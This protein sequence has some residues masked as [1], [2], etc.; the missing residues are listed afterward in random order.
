MRQ[1]RTGIRGIGIN[2]EVS[3]M[4]EQVNIRLPDG[5]VEQYDA[6]VTPLEVAGRI[7]ARLAAAAVAAKVNGKSVDLD[8]KITG[9][10]DLE[11]ITAD[12]DE[13]LEILRHSAAHIMAQAVKRLFPEARLGI[14]PAIAEGFYY[15]FDIPQRLSDDDLEQIEAEMGRIVSADYEFKRSVM[16]AEEAR[17]LF[18]ASGEVYKLELVDDI[19]EDYVSIYQQG[20]FTDL[21]RGPHIPATGR[22]KAFKLLS[23]AGAYWQGDTERPMLQRV[24]G[25]AFPKNKELEEYIEKR[26]EAEKRDHRKLGQQLDL[27]SFHDAGPGFPFLHPKGLIIR[28]QLEDFL[29]EE[30]RRRGYEEIR[31]PVILNEGLWH[32]SGHWDHYKENMY[33][34]QIDDDGYAI[35]PMN[36]PGAML[37]YR[38]KLHSYR[39]L[40]V[41]LCEMGVVHRHELS[42]VLQGLMR[43]RCFTQDDAHLF[44]TPEQIRDEIKGIIQLIDYVYRDVFG[45]DY[46]IELSTRPENSMGSDEIWEHA[47]KAL[48]DALH[49]LNRGFSVNE[50]DGAFYGPKIDFHLRDCLDRTWQCGTIQLDFLMP[51][52]FGLEYV[53][54]DGEKHRP[55]VIH[56]TV[57]GSLERFMG[58]LIE[59]FAGAFPTW[60]APVQVMMIPVSS[61]HR[62]YARQAE[63]QLEKNGIRADVDER[64]EKV[65][66]KIRD[67][68]L[69]QVPYMLIVGE[70]EVGSGT[71]SVRHRREGDMGERSLADFI[72][73]IRE[74]IA[75]RKLPEQT[76]MAL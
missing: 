57:Y 52:R 16:P 48:R 19:G 13:G 35:K 32:Q 30:L 22:L 70:N 7:G 63:A 33:F 74:E 26:K 50:G 38:R 47:V 72:G 25:T 28:Q 60:L 64:D 29:R 44:V 61:E 73:G 51:E 76:P 34:T 4:K 11:I 42:G 68:Q 54:S 14:G 21:C 39:E 3:T 10:V 12:S 2:E 9:D 59:H 15:D 17:A 18:E 65:G 36:C 69:Q 5:S 40:P 62:D 66:Y 53:G 23:L 20:E 45:F 75:E 6:P 49:D 31:T 43:V 1:T 67:A 8:H 37:L 55:V 56:R 46:H 58:I 24:Y 41:R 71:V 27:F